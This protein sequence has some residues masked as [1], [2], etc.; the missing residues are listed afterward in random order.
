MSSGKAAATCSMNLIGSIIMRKVFSTV[1]NSS[2]INAIVSNENLCL[3][4]GS[5]KAHKLQWDWKAKNL[6]EHPKIR[7]IP[8]GWNDE[9][10]WTGKADVC[11]DV[12]DSKQ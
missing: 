9:H 12:I 8:E 10:W 4:M 1:T 3:E 5:T 7:A 6:L 11:K 2:F